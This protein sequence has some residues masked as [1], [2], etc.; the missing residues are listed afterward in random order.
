MIHLSSTL[1]A[2]SCFFVITKQ[3]TETLRFKLLFNQI[4]ASVYNCRMYKRT[5]Y[6]AYT[7]H[8]LSIRTPIHCS[9]IDYSHE[10]QVLGSVL[11]RCAQTCAAHPLLY[12]LF[13]RISTTQ[14]PNKDL[15][16]RKHYRNPPLHTTWEWFK[17]THIL[18]R[19]RRL[20][21]FRF[22]RTVCFTTVM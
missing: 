16:S 13:S 18:L 22:V 9:Y 4:F 12:A 1:V 10:F 20:R 5:P 21:T 14:A 2:L 15:V 11:A 19:P 3:F 7:V 6:S 8:H 17:R